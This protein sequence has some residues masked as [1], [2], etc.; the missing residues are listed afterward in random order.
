MFELLK[1]AQSMDYLSL[2]LQLLAQK[3]SKWDLISVT[4]I[5]QQRFPVVSHQNWIC[6]TF[7]IVSAKE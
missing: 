5:C 4:G 1:V 3:A 7:L 2:R 6:D